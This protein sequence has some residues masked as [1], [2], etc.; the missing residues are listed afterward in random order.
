LGGGGCG[1]VGG[2]DVTVKLPVS[3]ASGGTAGSSGKVSHDSFT[4]TTM[5]YPPAGASAG[6]ADSA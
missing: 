5:L 1:F 3:L 2:G 4:S 6:T